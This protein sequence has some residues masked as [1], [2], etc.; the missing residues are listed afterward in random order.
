MGGF[1][2]GFPRGIVL[3]DLF[4]YGH[5]MGIGLYNYLLGDCLFGGKSHGSLFVVSIPGTPLGSSL[6]VG[7]LFECLYQTGL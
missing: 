1:L 4:G 3:Y 5:P 2:F 6:S 7:F